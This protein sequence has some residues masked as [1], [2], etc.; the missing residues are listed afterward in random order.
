MHKDDFAAAKL[1]RHAQHFARQVGIAV[2]RQAHPRQR[3]GP[4]GVEPGG[5][6]DQLRLE[7]LGGSPDDLLED[8]SIVASP[9]PG[10]SGTLMV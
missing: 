10:G 1:L 8:G 2:Q 9:Q 5:N 4:M 7:A 6:E 3:V